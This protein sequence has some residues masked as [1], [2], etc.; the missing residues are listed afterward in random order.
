METIEEVPPTQAPP[1]Q[2]PSPSDA[3][4]LVTAPAS[5]PIPLDI[6]DTLYSKIILNTS[7]LSTVHE[8]KTSGFTNAS[9]PL[10]TISIITL[11]NSYTAGMP[12]YVL[13]TD[14]IQVL[15]ERVYNYLVEKYDL[16]DAKDRLAMYNLFDGC[17]KLCLAIPNVKKEITSCLKVFSCS[18]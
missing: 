8:L 16:I 17:L 1:T 6:V 18:K 5:A 13:D 2:A 9:I 4:T 12:A 7:L 11:Y 15:L 14:D 3:Q 10:L